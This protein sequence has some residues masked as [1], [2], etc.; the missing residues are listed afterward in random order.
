M[1]ASTFTTYIN[2]REEPGAYAAFDK[3]ATVA[4]AR[5]A[6]ITRAANEAARAAAGVIGGTG[7]VGRGA[8]QA[9]DLKAFADAQRTIAKASGDSSRALGTNAT[10][11]RNQAREVGQAATKNRTFASSLE[12]TST[13]LNLAQG[14]L[15]PL[16]SRVT[17]LS[18]AVS[19]LTGFQVGLA[20][21]GA[22]IFSVGQAGAS[23]TELQAKLRPFFETQ[24]QSNRAF[25]ESIAIAQRSRAPLEAV[26][27]L[28]GRL[29]AVA[30]DVGIAQGRVGRVTELA[31]KAATLSG[32]SR[33]TQKAGLGQFLQGIGSN[34]LGG[35]EL[36]SVKEN[37]FALAQAIAA[38]FK[39][40]DGSIG[41]TIGNLKELGS[42]GKLTA[43]VVADALERSA[44]SIE[45]KYARLPLTL[46]RAGTAF[47][48]SL[49]TLVGSF[50]QSVG[51]TTRLATSLEFIADNLRVVTALALGV[52]AAFAAPTAINAAKALG[53]AIDATT[54]QVIA[55]RQQ[56]KDADVEW[57]AGYNNRLAQ[58]RREQ[59]ALQAEQ[60]QIRANIALLERQRTV[61]AR[62]IQR[63]LPTQYAPGGA[64][65]P[66][67]PAKVQAASEE[68]RRAFRAQAEEQ[69]RLNVINKALQESNLR[70]T[71][72]QT[73]LANAT[74]AVAGRMGF[75]RTAAGSLVSFLG[76]PWGI[77]FAVATTALTL[78]ATAQSEAEKATSRNEV[79]QRNFEAAIDQTTGKIKGQIGALQ[80]LS[81]A[82]QQGASFQDAIQ[83]A[84]SRGGA[85]FNA[86]A[87]FT[88]P[89]ETNAFGALVPSGRRP[90][91]A[92]QELA[93]YVEAFRQGKAGSLPALES[94]I[95]RLSAAIPG[96]KDAAP[97]LGG[98]A[99]D[100]QASV[101][102]GQNT[103][104]SAAALNLRTAAARQ[105]I[106]AGRARPGD[107]DIVSGRAEPLASTSQAKPKT[108]AQLAAEA[109]GYAAQTDLQR[110]K[111]EEAKIRANGRQGGETDD[112]YVQRLGAA[113]Q[114]VRALTEAEKQQRGVRSAGA[115]E[116]RKEARDAQ[117][118]ALDAAT[119]KRDA[120]LLGL[121]KSDL[122]PATIEFARRREAIIKTYQD[123][124]N[125]IDASRAASNAYA[126]EQLRN[127]ERLSA[128]ADKNAEKRSDI[129]GQYGDQPRPVAR[130]NDQIDD[131]QKLVGQYIRIRGELVEYTQTQF[132][133]DARAIDAGLRRP[134]NDY[135]KDREREVEISRLVL[136]GREAEAAALRTAYGLYDQI[137]DL[138]QGDYELLVRDAQQQEK[139]NSL[140]ASRERIT[141]VI[142]GTV[143]DAR[144][145][146]TQFLTDLPTKGSGAFGDLFKNI[147]AQALKI[148]A[149]KITESLFA[150][151]D[152]KVESLLSGRNSV[153]RAIYQF[154]GSIGEAQSGVT[155][156]D[157]SFTRVETSADRLATSLETASARIAGAGQTGGAGGFVGSSLTS[158]P[159]AGIGS[160]TGSDLAG[161]SDSAST[162]A[163]AVADI[164]DAS[165]IMTAAAGDQTDIVVTARKE[166]KPATRQVALS[167]GSV[168]TTSQVLKATF[169]GLFELGNRLLN[170]VRGIK[171][172]PDGTFQNSLGQTVQGSQFFTKIGKSF[173]DALAGSGKG[174]LAS[175][176]AGAVGVPQNS[177]GAAIGG[178][179]GGILNGIKGVSKFLGPLGGALEPVL[180]IVGGLFG[181]L[182]A[183][184]PKAK[185][186][187]IT[188]VDGVITASGTGAEKDSVISASKTVQTSIA[189]IAEALNAEVGSFS[190]SIA[191]YKDSY[192]VDPTGSGS[193]GGKYGDR[194]VQG[195]GKFD[196]N[197]VAGAVAF[198]INDAIKDGAIK[199]I[200]AGTQQLLQSGKDLETQLRKAVSFENVFKDL[201]ARTDP[202]GYAVDQVNDKF[203]RL[204]KIFNEA[205]ATAQEY[206]DLSKLYELERADAIKTAT[207]QASSA[208]D[209]FLKDMVGSSASPL[210]KR[211]TYDNAASE[212]EKFK[213][214]IFS[215]KQVD[216]NALLSAARNFQDASKALNG[217]SGSF[218]SDFQAL[219][220]LLVKARDNSAP[221]NL[222]D[223]AL[224]PL[225]SDPTVQAK[226]AELSQLQLDATNTQTGVLSSQLDTLISLLSNSSAGGGGGAIGLL[227]GFGGGGGASST[228]YA[229]VQLV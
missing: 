198:A 226:L 165:E 159:L 27:D 117:Q 171:R 108:R 41:T 140:L 5:Y 15:G 194:F 87:A 89:R 88:R 107:L 106:I 76:G 104:G 99:R 152:E 38:G 223:L 120:S 161:I 148:T 178:G 121:A 145:S 169:G 75:L 219:Q 69:Q 54:R 111:A 70:V 192:R 23:Y 204:I 62:D 207:E 96:L 93:G 56:A 44:D 30:G 141:S 222:T 84:R 13:A 202:L 155:R 73:G 57:V 143:D 28:Y 182:F 199:G 37:T 6:T 34:N 175:G 82:K 79:A 208:I 168:P 186:S 174:L 153:D 216:Q 25:R 210:N 124:V 67:D 100:F 188:S 24:E 150:G 98:L 209:Q 112:Q 217:S 225:A 20:G 189:Q 167:Q 81:L 151:A 16:A 162:L 55:N 63:N 65:T 14:R 22:A 130:A 48:N 10:A 97:K 78:F 160:L 40:A 113:I 144:N 95:N 131:L 115:R 74:A 71:T 21:V 205:G 9:R 114:N 19:E 11:V 206:G 26:A 85:L 52:G 118:D 31:S 212:I 195:I 127:A 33:E 61:A 136:Q 35:D 180:G 154:N 187:A 72:T 64:Y 133:A 134:F 53:S 166:L 170:D 2:T 46:S 139:I 201:K 80:Q 36:R 105:R 7:S 191:K 77:A 101:R 149:T 42:Q 197:D 218:F 129:L 146:F 60:A 110:A 221:S 193:D 128:A 213:G 138:R 179:I 215:G 200:R 68:L 116:A 39:N 147:Q 224:S 164:A 66:G 50:D 45:K 137:G 163:K 119:R 203:S 43:Q 49:V 158:D 109:A 214:D 220:N 59:T 17:T 123:E 83:N 29:S 211:T 184:T 227:P 102:G 183:P 1:R 90:S 94:A 190:V 135:L 122:G 47:S 18:R 185:G 142:R 196:N 32:G 91:A 181:S 3:L 173:S 177:T 125:A 228:R 229:N 176:I 157:G 86:A 51:L 8:G 103:D 156:L 172:Q 92:Q 4:T 58:H 126:S 12:A 132:A